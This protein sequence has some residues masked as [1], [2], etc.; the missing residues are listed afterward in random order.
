[1]DL[2]LTALR[3]RGAAALLLFAV[4][5]RAFSADLTGRTSIIDGDTIATAKLNEIDPQ[6]W[7]ADVM[8]RLPD[9]PAKRI[10]KLL[11]WIWR[12]QNVTRAAR[13]N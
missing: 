10:H 9:Y 12:P 6:A 8:A 2:F 1:L 11:P 5:G 3:H 13:D 7:L 4:T